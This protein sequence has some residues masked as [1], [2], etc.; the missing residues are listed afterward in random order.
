MKK[1]KQELLEEI[2][3]FDYDNMTVL[4]IGDTLEEESDIKI[5]AEEAVTIWHIIQESRFPGPFASIGNLF[6]QGYTTIHLLEVGDE[7]LMVA[8]KITN[9][10]DLIKGL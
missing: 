4:D 6:E 7:A 3:M 10:S 2:L 9:L 1:I 8:T 5:S